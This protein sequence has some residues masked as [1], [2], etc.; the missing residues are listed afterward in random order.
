MDILNSVERHLTQ[1]DP[2]DPN[3]PQ[4]R[5][6]NIISVS[7]S[8]IALL[9]SIT[10]LILIKKMG[11][12]N[13]QISLIWWMSVCQCTYDASFFG[14]ISQTEN[15]VIYE[16]SA[17]FQ[18]FGGVSVTLFTNVITFLL[19]YV[20]VYRKNL[21]V[22]KYFH[23]VLMFTLSPAVTV[24]IMYLTNAKNMDYLDKILS[25]TYYWLRLGA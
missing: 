3:D 18:L 24:G 12:W 10:I 5:A 21:D 17:F 22:F 11:Q 23:L 7:F 14:Y 20:I 6:V 16:T 13:P 25:P 4:K 8:V 9:C 1:G 2:F 19:L 15:K